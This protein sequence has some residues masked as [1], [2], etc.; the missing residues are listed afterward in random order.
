MFLFFHEPFRFL[1]KLNDFHIAFIRKMFPDLRA[2]RKERVEGQ[3]S[4]K[5]KASD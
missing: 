3:A 4:Q 5:G 2:R 1:L